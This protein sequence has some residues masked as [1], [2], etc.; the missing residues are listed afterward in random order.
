M[1]NRG[2]LCRSELFNLLLVYFLK[3]L[4]FC[5][6]SCFHVI[7]STSQ[8]HSGHPRGCLPAFVSIYMILFVCVIFRTTVCPSVYVLLPVCLSDRTPACA[9]FA[10]KFKGKLPQNVATALLLFSLCK[11][12][13]SREKHKQIGKTG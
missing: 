12:C 13:L 7:F 1:D 9:L 11:F 5:L 8:S 6:L 3:R 4:S 2:T 10:I